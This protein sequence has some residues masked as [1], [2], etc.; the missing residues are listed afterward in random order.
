MTRLLVQ[1]HRRLWTSSLRSNPSQGVLLAM[2]GLYSFLGV[3][4]LGVMAAVQGPDAL[5]A[6]TALGMAA[7]VILAVVMP[8]GENQLHPS[9]LTALPLT[10]REIMPGL[11]LSAL[12]TTR[13]ILSAVCTM[14]WAVFAVVVTDGS[15]LFLVGSVM[16]WVTT[17]LLGELGTRLSS[18]VAGSKNNLVMALSGL[19]TMVLVFGVLQLQELIGEDFPLDRIGAIAAWTPLGA[20][21]GWTVGSAPLG[22]LAVAVATIAVAA[23]AWR[24]LVEREFERPMGEEEA[25]A[26][27]KAKAFGFGQWSYTSPWAMEYTRSLRYLP[28][29]SRMMGSLILVPIAVLYMVYQLY[30][31]EYFF[32]LLPLA[33]VALMAGMMGSNDFGYDGPAN[34]VKLATPVRPRVF[35][36]ARHAANLTPIVVTLL[37]AAGV[38]I[39]MWPEHGLAAAWSVAALGFAVA[40]AAFGLLLTVVNPFPTAKPGTNPW[41]D[42]SGYAAAPFVSAFFMMFLGWLPVLPGGIL[43]S[44]GRPVIGA[45]VAVALP[46]VI[47]AAIAR[48]SARRIDSRLPEIYARVGR[49]VE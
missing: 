34:W 39:A 32:A 41:S 10:A 25:S 26:R 2:L 7:Y 1:L 16:A 20:A 31:G 29:D 33:M 22:K 4:S 40:A 24:R 17:V 47:Y 43:I 23:W 27:V 37:V 21:T 15:V 3:V 49:W 19:L 30:K 5:V 12:W 38:L 46:A 36:F 42:K 28:R 45:V 35:L 13:S 48:F 44:V 6:G 11:A 8:A 14:L 18:R 9:K